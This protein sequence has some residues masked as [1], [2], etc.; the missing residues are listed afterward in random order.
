MPMTYDE[1]E[2]E[3]RSLREELRTNAAILAETRRSEDR[4]FRIFLIVP[5]LAVAILGAMLAYTLNVQSNFVNKMDTARSSLDKQHTTDLATQR[6]EFATLKKD[7]WKENDNRLAEFRK[8]MSKDQVEGFAYTLGQVADIRLFLHDVEGAVRAGLEQFDNATRSNTN[9][10]AHALDKL[11]SA[12]HI[13][14]QDQK[15]IPEELLSQVQSLLERS[16]VISDPR[17][18]KLQQTIQSYR[19]MLRN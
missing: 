16:D 17:L 18:I 4:L 5:G 19:A 7:L 9:F 10:Q 14:I 15:R 3:I 11:T 2:Q 12:F 6:N 1:M 13:G 8:D